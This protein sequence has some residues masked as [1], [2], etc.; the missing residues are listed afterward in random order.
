MITRLNHI[1]TYM[2]KKVLF[3]LLG[4]LTAGSLWAQNKSYQIEKGEKIEDVADKFNV[5][6]EAILQLNPDLL[7][8]DIS[9]KV[10]VIPP[11]EVN[12]STP[13]AVGIRF[14]EYRVKPKETL[15]SLAKENGITI[16]DI[17][18]Y[19]PYLYN[20]TLGEND[21]IRI[22]IFEN[23]KRDFNTSIQTST[24]KNIV[25]IVMPKETKYGIS[26]KYNM[27]IS[28]LEALNPQIKEL[29]PGQI[30]KVVNHFSKGNEEEEAG[31]FSYYEVQ[32]KETLYSL[33]RE[34][35][36]SKDSLEMYNPI[37][38]ELGLQAGMEL[39]IPAGGNIA[40]V[41]PDTGTIINLKN[42][43]Q[44][45]SSKNIAVMLPFN[46]NNYKDDRF[47]NGNI[48]RKDEVSQISLDLYSG[49]KIAVD[50][51]QKL[52]IP[53]HVT[54]F[55][56]QGSAQKVND[57][58][59]Q[60]R[61]Q[62]YQLIIGPL[63]T[64]HLKTVAQ[65]LKRSN[66]AVFSPVVNTNLRGS[67]K[68]MQTRPTSD[69]KE[70]LLISYLDSLQTGKNLLLISDQKHS[71]LANKLL[72]H[73]PGMRKITQASP[74]Y[75]QRSDLTKYLSTDR[76]NWI[77]IETSDYGTISNAFSNLNAIRSNYQIR[78]F[79]SDKNR[80]YDEEVPKEFLGNLDFTYTSVDKSDVNN[81]NKYF[82]KAYTAA[83]GITPNAYAVRGFDLAYDALLRSATGRDVFRS[84]ATKK[85]TTEYAENR[86]HYIKDRSN[87]YYNNAVYLIKFNKDL[88]LEVLN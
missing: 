36:I 17:K 14:K 79:T 74:D 60:N 19:N 27:R 18:K 88:T 58:L 45:L 37:L 25:H 44:N 78:I 61:L 77:I 26:K 46:L 55:D 51:I 49:I 11:K 28:E 63:L 64:A 80:I 59:R 15:Y 76:P 4:F 73:F 57:I 53:V 54:T 2:K 68:L 32:P 1:D 56:T 10:I 9:G 33:T 75:L 39:K 43:I 47:E 24:F 40:D 66:T 22:P 7:N 52:G 41:K 34:L 20:A 29:Q 16:E 85:G 6:K 5:S 3:I 81:S 87:G 67:D 13:N 69:V 84:L 86:F 48:L 42:E 21:M 50:S 72:N 30:L 8:G 71:A 83:Y 35:G 82:V 70:N 31:A 23:E 65:E 62:N 12:E 38:K